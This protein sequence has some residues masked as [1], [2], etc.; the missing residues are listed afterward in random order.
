ME[1]WEIQQD[2]E[3]KAQLR[4]GAVGDRQVGLLLSLP[5]AHPL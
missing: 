2:D 3:T 1:I 5:F 4:R